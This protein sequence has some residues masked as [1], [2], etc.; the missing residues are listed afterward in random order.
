MRPKFTKESFTKVG[1]IEI[2]ITERCSSNL[3]FLIENHFQKD[4][5]AFKP[6][7]LTPNFQNALFLSAYF[8]SA[9]TVGKEMTIWG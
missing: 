1:K 5:N 9:V 8:K 2:D 6:L 4:Q 3:I 7:K